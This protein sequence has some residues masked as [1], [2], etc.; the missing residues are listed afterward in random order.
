VIIVQFGVIEAPTI[1]ELFIDKIVSMILSGS[2]SVGDR[3]PTERELAEEMKVSKTIVH[4]GLK[5][6][7]RMGFVCVNARQGTF[8]ANYAETGNAETL[9][10]IIKFNGGKMDK[11][12]MISLLEL[13]IAVEGQ[14]VRKF[15]ERHTEEDIAFLRKRLDV[16]ETAVAKGVVKRHELALMIFDWHHA[17]CL[18][19]GNDILPLVLNAFKDVSVFFWET[20][21]QIYGLEQSMGHLES[22]LSLLI[23]G[24]GEEVVQ[25]MSNGTDYYITHL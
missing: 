19:S 7:E 16:I 18:R 23:E 4:A 13:R 10:T 20:S 12:T 25:Y 6:L 9:T 3:L 22:I 5:D 24:K 15:A 14:A 17:I 2:L 21:L 1:K 11:Q 8:I